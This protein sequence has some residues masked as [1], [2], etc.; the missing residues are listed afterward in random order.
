MRVRSIAAVL[1]AIAILAAAGWFTRDYWRGWFPSGQPSAAK[2]KEDAHAHEDQE[3][4]KLSK[5]ARARL[6][7]VSEPVEPQ[8]Y[9]RILRVP[10]TVVER[11]GKTD[12]GVT[13]PIAGVVKRIVAL[14]GDTVQ[15]GAELFTL[16][17]TSESL[18]NS[19]TELFKN[20]Q[21]RKIE[22]A[23]YD[24]LLMAGGAVP[25]S[26]LLDAKGQL[27]R[28]AALRTAQRIDLATRGLT[29]P[30]IDL[31]EQGEFLKELT[32]RAAIQPREPAA[33][34]SGPPL[35]ELE[36]LKVQVGEQVQAGQVLCYLSNHQNLYIEGRGFKEDAALLEEAAEKGCPITV[37]FTGET[38]GNWK[39]AGENFVIRYLANALDADSQTF[40]FFI[41]LA[42]DYREYSR[43]GKT[44]RIWRYR[45][46]QRARLGVRVQK[47]EN[48]FV[49]PAEAVVR[50]GAEDY[51][52]R[53]NGDYFDRKP[54]HVVYEDH[55]STVIANDGSIPPGNHIARN[56]AATLNR[57]LKAKSEGG[58]GHDHGG[59]SH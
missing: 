39:S 17:L 27:D 19:Q 51:I 53:Q 37:E 50:E 40:P 6:Q 16:T 49:L 48:V 33:A 52:F 42:N 22:Q 3:R 24:R 35:Y 20:T 41:P 10:G 55:A 1:A 4:V 15:P 5:Q 13:T 59:H 29:P 46:G 28:L 7:L 38:G 54:V 26:R 30:Q 23:R 44:Y 36:D 43:D 31:V 12:L 21:E 47:F 11:R 45:P 9:W 32:I 2:K 18:L 8:T 34:G 57:A 25:E 14:A 56:A 58:G